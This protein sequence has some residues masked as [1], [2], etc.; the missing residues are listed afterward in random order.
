MVGFSPDGLYLALVQTFATGG[1]GESSPLQ[2]RR[3]ADG[4]LVYSAAAGTMAVWASVPSRLFFR[5]PPGP[6][7]AGTRAPG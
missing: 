2:I 1:S 3:V 5:T 7:S 4:G 6:C